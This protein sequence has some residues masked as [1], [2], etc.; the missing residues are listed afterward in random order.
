MTETL[1][2]VKRL[3]PKAL[4]GFSPYPSCYNGDP[5]QTMLANYTGQCPA[6]E[7]ALNDELLWLWKRC[8]AL[9]PLL[10]L[11]KLQCGTSGARLHLSSQ[12][13][14]ALR[15]ECQDLAEF[16]HKV[17]G[18]YSINVTTAT[19]RCSASLCQ[20]KGRCVRQNPESSV[21]LHLPATSKLV[22]KVSEK[23]RE[24]CWSHFLMCFV[25]LDF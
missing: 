6:E 7:M 23:V 24:R 17:L 4:W 15:R 10:T 19:R 21:Y 2:E 3:R 18:P 12:I 20:G 13:R 9:Y 1:R 8:S 25:T 16:V 11:E 5:A 22:E 14:E